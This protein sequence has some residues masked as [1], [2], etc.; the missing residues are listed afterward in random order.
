MVIG[1]DTVVVLGKK[2]MG[3]PYDREHATEMLTALSNKTHLVIT[4]VCIKYGDKTVSFSEKTKVTFRKITAEE[5]DDYIKT[6]EP[7]DK[8]G[9]YG[10]QGQGALFVKQ[11]RGDYFNIVGLPVARLYSELKKLLG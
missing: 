11:I 10:I 2:I 1:C 9:S 6:F 5:I 4:G 3:K 8:A 7:F